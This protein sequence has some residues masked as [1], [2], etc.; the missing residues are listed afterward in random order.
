[1]TVGHPPLTSD[2]SAPSD[3]RTERFGAPTLRLAGLIGLLAFVL[4]A[5]AVGVPRPWRDE[6]ATH[7]ANERTLPQLWSML[8]R[9]DAV[10]GTYYLLVRV[11]QQLFGE[12]I[13]SLRML[14]VLA[15]AV[16]A[17]LMTLLGA[18][19]F[20]RATGLWAGLGYALL[21]P[22]TGAAVEARSYALATALVTGAMLAFRLATRRRGYLWWVC[23]TVLAA[24]SIYVFLYAALA[25][26][27]LAVMLIWL[28]ARA[29]VSACVSTAAAAGLS[30]PLLIRVSGQSAQVSWLEEYHYGL[31]QI[32][33]DA[34]WGQVDWLAWLGVGLS[35]V[36]LGHAV[37]LL[38]EPALRAPVVWVLGWL[39]LPSVILCTVGAFAAVYHPRYLGFSVPALALLIGLLLSRLSGRRLIA[40]LVVYAVACVP[41]LVASRL[42]N[43][44][45]TAAAAVA[46]LAEN[47]RPGDALYI[48][49]YDRH[50]LAWSFPDAVQQLS[51]VGADTGDGWRAEELKQPSLGVR[52]IADRLTSVQRVWIFADKGWR[53]PET[54]AAF[55]HLGFHPLRTVSVDPGYPVT[56]VLLERT[57]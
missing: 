24:A 50:A 32:V 57:G 53:L 34:F 25:Y 19:L 29:R 4:N 6:A 9:I 23:Y 48:V 17:A 40:A 33:A 7:M 44:K 14:S 47:S 36:A 31:P 26:V 8:E 5:I 13:L 2:R 55:A 41:P 27:V 15:V 56:L 51:N 21:P 20:D 39:V 1:M 35:L 43:A 38:R 46:V 22:L 18:E 30:V 49:R 10:H 37:R 28:P 54:E 12:A 16:G 3:A 11:W 42:P 45:P 52:K